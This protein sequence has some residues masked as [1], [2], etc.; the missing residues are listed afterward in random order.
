MQNRNRTREDKIRIITKGSLRR[1][2]F[3]AASG[4]LHSVASRRK[5]HCLDSA[6]EKREARERAFISISRASFALNWP[7]CV[8]VELVLPQMVARSITHNGYYV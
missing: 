4:A 5:K 6:H 8:Y 7:S 3:L 2:S 1:G